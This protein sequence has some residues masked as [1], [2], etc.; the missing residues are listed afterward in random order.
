MGLYLCVFDGDEE[1]DGVELGSYA[2]FG[3]LRAAVAKHIEGGAEGS[4]CP[5]LMLHSDSD[6]E[7][8]PEEAMVLHSELTLISS[9]FKELPP[10][11]LGDGWK[12]QVAR[13]HGLYPKSLYDCFF[14]I[15]GEP[16]LERLSNLTQL[17]V[18]RKLPILFQ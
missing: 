18:E 2:D 10:E 8:S 14:D 11:P 17:S 6:G 7:W 4:K 9:R 15:D 3:T 1:I 5:T 12:A 13:E 16:L